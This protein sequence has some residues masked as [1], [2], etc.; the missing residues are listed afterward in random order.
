[1]KSTAASVT[2]DIDIRKY[3]DWVTFE[4]RINSL[5]DAGH[6]RRIA[7]LR[8][9]HVRDE[10]WFLEPISGDVYVYVRPDDK[11]LPTWE[12]VDIFA[13]T[14]AEES[15]DIRV[16]GLKIIPTGEINSQTA[17][18]LRW[19]LSILVKEGKL[20]II[21]TTTT[22]SLNQES[23]GNAETWYREFATGD[24]YRLIERDRLDRSFWELLSPSR[25]R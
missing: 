3:E 18:G 2:N 10:E 1:M 21:P 19:V 14:V 23:S 8:T 22:T 17:I 6:L 7:A 20:E 25:G 4:K 9:L 12:K 16:A 24:V 15:K 5:V 13:P 11:I